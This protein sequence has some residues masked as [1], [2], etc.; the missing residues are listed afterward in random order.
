MY[1]RSFVSS[2]PEKICV[3]FVKGAIYVCQYILAEIFRAS[4]KIDSAKE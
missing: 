4:I 1:A 3:I 2:F